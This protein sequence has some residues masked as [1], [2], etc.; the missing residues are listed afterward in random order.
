MKISS[1]VSLQSR[2]VTCLGLD[3]IMLPFFSVWKALLKETHVERD[4]SVLKRVG[5]KSQIVR[6]WSD[7]LGTGLALPVLRSLLD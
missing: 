5:R 7:T 4:P 3:Q 1:T 2:F 6:R